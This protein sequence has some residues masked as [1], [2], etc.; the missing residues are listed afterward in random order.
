MK[1]SMVEGT[2]GINGSVGPIALV[3]PCLR[4][5]KPDHKLRGSLRRSLD[6]TLISSPSTIILIE[7]ST[8]SNAKGV[9]IIMNH[10]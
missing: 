9:L 1:G 2:W 4:V 8:M 10:H 6:A 7:L 3:Q 5:S